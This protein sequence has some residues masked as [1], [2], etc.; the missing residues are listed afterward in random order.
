[1]ADIE[2]DGFFI[3]GEADEASFAQAGRDGARAYERAFSSATKKSGLGDFGARKIAEGFADAGAKVGIFG[4]GAQEV[5]QKMAAQAGRLRDEMMDVGDASGKAAGQAKGFADAGKRVRDS[6]EGFDEE[7]KKAATSTKDFDR[8][9]EELNKDMKAN[10]ATAEATQ[11]AL[12]EIGAD[13]QLLARF[14]REI[15]KMQSG[16]RAFNGDLERLSRDENLFKGYEV[17]FQNM[18]REVFREL[19]KFQS[20]L[21]AFSKA[22]SDR[23]QRVTAIQV[24]ESKARLQDRRIAG[25]K[26]IS[27][28]QTLG[29][30]EVA[31]FKAAAA[32][33]LQSD[34]ATSRI[35]LELLRNLF[36]QVRVIER[37]IGAVFKGTA[38]VVAGAFARVESTVF[39]IAGVFRRGNSDYTAGLSGSL[40][41]REGIIKRSFSRQEADVRGSVARQS[42]TIQRFETQ[43]STGIAGALSGRSSL[44]ALFGGGLAIGGGFSLFRKLSQSVQVGGDF[45]QGLA[46]LQAQLQLTAEEMVG[47]RQLSID[48][49]NDIT[50]PGVS[51]L[52]AAQAIAAL[53]KQFGALGDAAL[54]AAESAAKGVLS[55]SRATGASAE[56]AAALVGSATNVFGISADEAVAT[57]DKITA[58]LT[59]AAGVGITE[60]KDSFTQAANVFALFQKPAVGAEGALVGLNTALAVLARGGLTGSQAGTGLKQFFIQSVKAGDSFVAL[61]QQIADTAGVTGSVFFDAEGGARKLTDSVDILRRGLV[62]LSDEQR[63]STLTKLFGARA[64]T[65]ASILIGASVKDFNDLEQAQLRAGAAADIAAAQNIG[66]RGALDALQSVIETQQIKTYE[67]WQGAIAKVVLK[68]AD[69]FQAFFDGTGIMANI[70][71]AITGVTVALGGLLALKASFELFKFLSI[72]LSGLISPL[73][74]VVAGT[75]AL[76]AAIALLLK[77]SPDFG[78]ALSDIGSSLSNVIAPILGLVGD[79]F[80]AF[81]SLVNDKVIPSVVD[82]SVKLAQNLREQ[83]TRFVGF[84]QTSVLPALIKFKDA[85]VEIAGPII[86]DVF[87]FIK[88]VVNPV[89]KTLGQ[90]IEITVVPAFEKLASVLEDKVDPAIQ[91]V[92]DV[93]QAI[94]N[95]IGPLVQPATDAFKA[96]GDAIGAIAGKRVGPGGTITDRDFSDLSAL[97]PA[98]QG[99]VTGVAQSFANIGERIIEVLGPQLVKVLGFVTGFFTEDRLLGIVAAFGR[100]AK[101]IGK[102][103]GTVVSSPEFLGAVTAIVASAGFIAVQFLAGL[104]QGLAVGLPRTF[105]ALGDLIGPLFNSLLKAAFNPKTIAKAILAGFALANIGVALFRTLQRP[106]ATAGTQAGQEAGRRSGLA[107]AKNFASSTKGAVTGAASR[108]QFATGLFGGVGA[109]EKAA[110]TEAAKAGRAVLKEQKIM[111]GRLRALGI[112]SPPLLTAGGVANPAVKETLRNITTQLGV[113]GTAGAVLR[114][115]LKQVFGDIGAV[116]KSSASLFRSGFTDGLSGVR[117]AFSKLRTDLGTTMR[118]I[119]RDLKAISVGAGQA[120]G[121][122]LLAGIGGVLSGRQL[123]AAESKT[124]AGLGLAGLFA[125][126]LFGGAAVGGGLQGAAV[127]GTILAL[128]GIAAVMER[129]GRKAKEAAERIDIYKQAILD[130]KDAAAANTDLGQ[131]LEDALVGASQ[132]TRNVLSTFGFDVQEFI[133][134]LTSGELAGRPVSDALAA[135]MGLDPSAFRDNVLGPGAR[136]ELVRIG[137]DFANAVAAGWDEQDFR[138]RINPDPVPIDIPFILQFPGEGVGGNLGDFIGPQVDQIDEALLRIIPTSENVGTALEL[139]NQRR[140]EDLNAQLSDVT[141][142]LDLVKAAADEAR[143]GLFE[144]LTGGYQNSFQET[145]DNAVVAIP[146][147]ATSLQEAFTIDGDELQAATIGGIVGNFRN[148][149]AG[150]I[151]KFREENPLV[152]DPVQIRTALAPLEGVIDEITFTDAEGVKV[153]LPA[154]VKKELNRILSEVLGEDGLEA[155]LDLISGFE[156]EARLL[157][158]QADKI[159]LKINADVIFTNRQ[160]NDALRELFPDTPFRLLTAEETLAAQRDALAS[161]TSVDPQVSALSELVNQPDFV[162]IVRLLRL[163]ANNP[164]A[165]FPGGLGPADQPPIDQSVTI[166]NININ[167]AEQPVAVGSEVIRQFVRYG[168]TGKER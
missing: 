56:D 21:K 19:G 138:D 34:R 134:I 16:L 64:S 73:G 162:E 49:G 26:E 106:M 69:L 98:L 100:V 36:R 3:R 120:I 168:Q 4:D 154:D 159:K 8:R 141:G 72:G 46:V 115:N 82:F 14:D 166:E 59:R 37:S 32:Q 109:L 131:L 42:V 39:R 62:G 112:K 144:L 156:E 84:L 163:E 52:D 121:G 12:K 97:G 158:E 135:A 7:F 53:A 54:P 91:K 145:L 85:F 119:G 80:A 111:A 77:S 95:E 88:G 113:A 157:Q 68:L 93:G 128:G 33:K 160:V 143:A 107:F 118:N 101:G 13:P 24:Q 17:S 9:V 125:S 22:Q 66:L 57:A 87:E 63:A 136:E 65:V 114:G 23:E 41:K 31:E 155:A 90:L 126:A 1:M 146:G 60:F 103:L 55:L 76:G 20:T 102:A 74:L 47:V 151:A 132:E 71:T 94:S 38:A 140:L 30:K 124:D 89:I 5:L 139:L 78:A 142:E 164:P 44:G 40:K 161:Q 18:S 108:N 43:A 149:I 96:L 129:S 51:A 152:T 50:L 105:A 123:G 61:R 148:V 117:L 58:A 45:I 127:A 81:A 75:A 92:R 79:A 167:G 83:L 150:A 25:G 35:R 153:G 147:I 130:A 70:R 28:I 165:F 137:S 27:L 29:A 10:I 86:R 6:W 11:K 133:R 2:G 110:A 67:K 48:L 15:E 122:A 116:G 104:A 99:V